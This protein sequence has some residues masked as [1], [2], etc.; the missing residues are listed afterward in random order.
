MIRNAVG[1]IVF[2]G[3]E[4][5]LVHKVKRSALKASEGQTKGEWDFPKGGVED[6]D[7]NLK[8]AIL[9][10]L[11]EE[12][13]SAE[14]RIIKQLQEKICFDFDREFAK[15]TGW[16]RQE[17]VMFVVEY[18]GDR[19]DLKAEDSEINEVEFVGRNEALERLAHEESKAF[20][21]EVF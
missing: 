5:L 13:G 15:K 11:A 7:E 17:T 21:A 2:Q 4:Y 9:R 12:T 1:A 20:F 3:E 10:E 14:Y 19:S 16:S 18:V 8:D 6:S